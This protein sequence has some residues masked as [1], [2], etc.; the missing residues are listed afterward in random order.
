M[1]KLVIVALS[2][3]LAVM[4]VEPAHAQNVVIPASEKVL[5]VIDSAIDSSKVPSVIHEVCFT[6]GGPSVSCPNKTTFMEGK[7][8]ASAVTWPSAV[9]HATYHGYNVV[10]SALATNPNLK[11]VFIRVGEITHSS[12]STSGSQPAS[13]VNAIKWVS[14]NATKYSIDAVAISLEGY[15]RTIIGKSV[16]LSLSS[17]CTNNVAIESV[18]S[19]SLQNVP[20]FAATGN[21]ALNFVAFPACV[22][23]VQGVGAVDKAGKLS[24]STNRGPGLDVVTESSITIMN[25]RGT[26]TF[27][28]M[29]T[30]AATPIAAARYVTSNKYA[31]VELFINSFAK[32]DG[33]P[34][35]SK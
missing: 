34:Y 22:S 27:E 18:K 14:D 2:A 4:A 16:S 3:V 15:T 29:A 7:G 35:I 12:G 17:S 20:V 26:G 19:L 11:V 32:A 10:Q 30:S 9:N 33:Y 25:N 31:S 1:K 28:F 6:T 24:K 5:A 8:A 23:G 21:E 13:I